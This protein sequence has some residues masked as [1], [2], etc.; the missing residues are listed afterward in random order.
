M[1]SMSPALIVGLKPVEKRNIRS[2]LLHGLARSSLKK[3]RQ[4]QPFELEMYMFQ[5]CQS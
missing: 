2:I 3:D 5:V 1:L 4:K